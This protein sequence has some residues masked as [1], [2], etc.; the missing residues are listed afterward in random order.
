MPSSEL[1]ATEAIRIGQLLRQGRAQKGL[2]VESVASDLHLQPRQ[3]LAL[4]K[5]D[6]S[7][8]SSP[9][10][11]KGHLRACARLY[12]MDGNALVQILDA[13]LPRQKSPP[14]QSP[15]TP[16]RITASV[17]KVNRSV[18]QAAIVGLVVLLV[19]GLLW[20]VLRSRPPVGADSGHVVQSAPVSP[21]TTTTSESVEPVAALVSEPVD[22]AQVGAT[23]DSAVKNPA[24]SAE[25]PAAAVSAATAVVASEVTLHIEFLD[26]CTVRLKS[27]DDKTL[28]DRKHRKGEIFDMAVKAP[29]HVWFS[30]GTA[31]AVTFDGVA[32]PVPVKPGFQSV[33]FVLGGEQSANDNE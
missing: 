15:V 5:G 13:A 32:V 2:T 4:E 27:S 21:V 30:K 29:L 1:F 3:I 17:T 22:V 12:V 28:H 20:Q 31:V 24:V 11:V 9:A 18:V 10:I 25:S 7:G 19:A 16:I 23:A 33:D 14:P 6:Y 8:F 26:D